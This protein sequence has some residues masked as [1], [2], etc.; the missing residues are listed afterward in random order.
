MLDGCLL[1]GCVVGAAEAAGAAGAQERWLSLLPIEGPTTSQSEVATLPLLA[2]LLEA[3]VLVLAQ[4]DS[5]QKATRLA[6][7]NENFMYHSVFGFCRAI[8]AVRA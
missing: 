2:S 5:R 3:G 1:S 6:P 7:E 4:A 8:W